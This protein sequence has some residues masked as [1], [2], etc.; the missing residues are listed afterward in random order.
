MWALD[1]ETQASELRSQ[2]NRYALYAFVIAI[3]A[4]TATIVQNVIFTQTSEVLASRLRFRT[5]SAFLRQDVRG[6]CTFHA[7]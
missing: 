7:R 5:F 6:S 3:I 1:P 2:G 4:T